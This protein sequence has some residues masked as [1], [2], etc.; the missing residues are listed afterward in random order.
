MITQEQAEHNLVT[1]QPNIDKAQEHSCQRDQR[2]NAADDDKEDNNGDEE[3]PAL[4]DRGSPLWNIFAELLDDG[5]P[6]STND[7]NSQQHQ[8]KHFLQ[9]NA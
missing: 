3:L 1:K 2:H 7:N 8:L 5:E 4:S 9:H 6:L